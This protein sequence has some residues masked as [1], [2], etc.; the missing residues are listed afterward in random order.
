MVR[1]QIAARG[2]EDPEVLRAMRAVPRHR[3]V[4][5]ALAHSAYGDHALP[6]GLE[7]TI[8]QPYMVGLM[9]SLLE[10]GSG[11]R[12]LE[13]GTGSGYQAAVLSRI[14]QVVFTIERVQALALRAQSLLA[15]L[16][17]ENV[18]FRI[19]DGT[20]GWRRF[21]PFDAIVVTAGAPAPPAT[22]FEQLR[23]G[24]VLVAPVGPRAE[25]R[26][27]VLERREDGTVLERRSVPCTFV[28]LIGR[29]GWDPTAI[30]RR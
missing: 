13:V 27:L 16:G 5:P 30:D 10:V 19:G 1:E 15:D 22:L 18:V 26:L 7:Q 12:V 20:L 8:S 2:V 6:I 14:V 11:S 3:F 24:G 25:Q 21:A 17:Y 23:P 28:P 4:D 29:E 9:S